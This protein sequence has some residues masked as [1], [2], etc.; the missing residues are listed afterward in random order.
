[1]Q[2]PINIINERE[3]VLT[4][5]NFLL[6]KH[7]S[8]HDYKSLLIALFVP[9]Q[10]FRLETENISIIFLLLFLILVWSREL[11]YL[12]HIHTYVYIYIYV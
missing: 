11:H 4:L 8:V 1:M 6:G 10:Q 9:C 2:A 7:Y 12:G 3:I 5:V